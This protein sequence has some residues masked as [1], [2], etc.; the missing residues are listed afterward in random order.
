MSDPGLSHVRELLV[1]L[2]STLDDHGDGYGSGAVTRV[3]AGSTDDLRAFL[4]SNELWGGAG[5][6]ADQA[7][8]T[9]GPTDGR[10]AIEAALVNLGEVQITL[11]LLN[12]R[13][14]TWV[15]AFKHWQRDGL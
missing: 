1:R 12:E 5:S 14:K 11:G 15:E 10:R 13:T 4:T 6:I 8:I 7:G 2:R 9:G 3:L